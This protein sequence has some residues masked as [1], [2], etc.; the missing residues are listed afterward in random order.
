[1]A[2]EHR[3]KMRLAVTGQAARMGTAQVAAALGV[4]PERVTA[5]IRRDW[6]KA[7]RRNVAG[8][9]YYVVDD[10]DLQRFLYRDGAVLEYLTPSNEWRPHWEKGRA[11]VRSVMVEEAALADLMAVS[12]HTIRGHIRQVNGFPGPA[13]SHTGRA[14]AVWYNR[15]QVRNWLVEHPQ[16][17]PHMKVREALRSGTN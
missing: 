8:M 5:W 12:H 14:P 13:I 9:P 6:L 7:R 15:I 4:P 1:M 16:Y 17:D 10:E 3:E 11:W 2:F